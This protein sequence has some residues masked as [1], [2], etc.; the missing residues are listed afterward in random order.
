MIASKDA[1]AEGGT[2]ADTKAASREFA[3]AANAADETVVEG[4]EVI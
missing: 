4:I 1:A 3:G 2:P